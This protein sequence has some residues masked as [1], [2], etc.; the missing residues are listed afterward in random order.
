MS[1]IRERQGS[2]RSTGRLAGVLVLDNRDWHVNIN[3]RSVYGGQRTASEKSNLY[4]LPC[5]ILY[6]FLSS[7]VFWP[8]PARA[9]S[10][11]SKRITCPFFHNP[12]TFLFVERVKIVWG[13]DG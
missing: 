5:A 4:K 3:R 12:V 9:A 13:G 6:C 2:L 8:A 7:F 11:F 1:P 10:V